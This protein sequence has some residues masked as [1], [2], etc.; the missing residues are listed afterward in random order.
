M[1][2]TTNR[3]FPTDEE[4]ENLDDGG[5]AQ[6]IDRYYDGFY[7]DQGI[8]PTFRERMNYKFGIYKQG[9]IGLL[10][11][12][13]L[14]GVINLILVG[15]QHLWHGEERSNLKTIEAELKVGEREINKLEQGLTAIL[16]HLEEIERKMEGD[17]SVAEYNDLVDKLNSDIDLYTSNYRKYE[18]K[19]S[20]YNKKVE[21][22]NEL[23]EKI[24]STWYVVPIP[25]G[26]H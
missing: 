9:L 14:Y 15:G 25:I 7:K 16:S 19:I 4:F 24:G 23:A 1:D 17:I 12:A 11:V 22:A 20:A 2:M 5:K 13:V 10:A 26:K 21:E 18:Y 8:V 6:V 3:K